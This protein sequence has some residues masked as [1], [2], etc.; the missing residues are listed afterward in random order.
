MSLQIAVSWLLTLP[1]SGM[2][3]FSKCCLDQLLKMAC[4]EH[5]FGRSILGVAPLDC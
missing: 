1:S 3:W 2:I 5:K 4:Q